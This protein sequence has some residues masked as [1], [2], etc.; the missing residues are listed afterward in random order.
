MPDK[1]L[2]IEDDANIVELLRLNLTQLG[3]EF[4]HADNGEAGVE[5]ALHGSPSVVVLDLQLPRLNG[6]DVCKAIR[7]KSP[8]LPIIMLTSRNSEVDTVLGLELGADDYVTKPFSVAEL[9]A[10]IRARMRNAGATETSGSDD[11]ILSFGD[12]VIDDIR[13]TVVVRGTTVELTAMEFDLL[14]F[15]AHN[16]GRPFTRDELLQSVWCISCA[17]Y[18]DNVNSAILRLRKKIEKDPARP[19]RI[20]TVRGVGYKFVGGTDPDLEDAGSETD[21]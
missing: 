21:R 16:P 6:F 7:S 8:H 17:G 13:R 5:R 14:S 1:V 15:L 19:R 12:L 2:L 11:G 4:E 20:H 18:E 9:T 3:Y 10:R